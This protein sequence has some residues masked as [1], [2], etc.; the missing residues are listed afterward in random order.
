[1][2]NSLL[3]ERRL[4]AT[5]KPR[6]SSEEKEYDVNPLGLVLRD[7]A[8][9]LVCTFFGYEDVR[10]VLL[11]RMSRAELLA[12]PTTMPKGFDLDAHLAQGGVAF[13]RGGKITLRAL[14]STQ[15]AI[16]LSETPLAADQKLVPHDAARQV[17]EANVPDTT[18]LRG[19]I[20]MY[21]AGIEILA[22]AA[23]RK[24]FAENAR[25]LARVY[26]VT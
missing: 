16:T 12:E 24:E 1:M 19:W 14:V 5:Y 4:R 11:H 21:G 13:R 18:E 3:E 2:I 6:G 20:S 9:V 22:P 10:Q 15:L 25:R 8:F 23:L 7:G 17:L 26:A